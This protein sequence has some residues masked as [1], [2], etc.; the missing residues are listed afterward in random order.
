MVMT[1]DQISG[2]IGGQQVMFQNNA[3]HAHQISGVYG[4]GSQ[5]PVMP[6]QNPFPQASS[7]GAAGAM[8][9][10]VGMAMPGVAT[11]ASIAGGMIGGPMGMLDPF[12]MVP[13]AFR[14]GAGFARGAGVMGTLGG[15]GSAAMSNPMGAAGM[16]GRGLMAGSLAAAPYMMAGQAISTVGENIYQGVQNINQVGGIMG[17]QGGA[18][19]GMSRGQIR[20]VVGVLREFSSDDVMMSMKEAISL[21]DVAQR[22]GMLSGVNNVQQFK[23]RFKGLVEQVKNISEV[24]G[25]TIQEAAPLMGQANQMGLWTTKDITGFAGAAQTVGMQNAPHLMGAMQAG[26]GASRAMG[27]RMGAG[28]RMGQNMFMG[29][30]A[31]MGAGVLTP[32]SLMEMTGGV[33]G[34]QGMQMMAGQLTGTASR[35][36]GSP[37]GRLMMAGLGKFEE[38]RFTG[39]IDEEMLGRFT[40]GDISVGALQGIGRRRTGTRSGA[41]SYTTQSGKIGQEMMAQGGMAGLGQ[42]IQAVMEGAGA[43]GAGKD[44]Q[45]LFIQNLLG[46][47][48]GEAEMWQNL[49]QELPKIQERRYDMQRRA[50]EDAGRKLRDKRY[51][52]MAGM[53]DAIGHAFEQSV[54]PIQQMAEAASTRIGNQMDEMVNSFW[55]SAAPVNV[56]GADRRR[57]M[58]EG[59][60]SGFQAMGQAGGMLG[61]DFDMGIG[62]RVYAAS[63][64]SSGIVSMAENFFTQGT[65]AGTAKGLISRIAS[66]D[67]RSVGEDA[68][69]GAGDIALV[70]GGGRKVVMGRSRAEQVLKR[71]GMR[72]RNPTLASLGYGKGGDQDDLENN[73]QKMRNSYV[74]FMT[75]P[76]NA[77]KLKKLKKTFGG[78]EARYMQAVNRMLMDDPAFKDAAEKIMATG[79]SGTRTEK[80]L[81]M[82]SVLAKEGDAGGLTVDF[83]KVSEDAGADLPPAGER[84]DKWVAEGRSQAAELTETGFLSGA[85]GIGTFLTG[86]AL[87]FAGVAIGKRLGIIGESLTSGDIADITGAEWSAEA[88]EWIRGGGDPGNLPE[89]FKDAL[90]AGDKRAVRLRDT[91]TSMRESDPSSL[92]KF[93]NLLSREGLAKRAKFTEE[94]IEALKTSATKES[95]RFTKVSGKLGEGVA[96][97]YSKILDAYRSGNQDQIRGVQG[98]ITSLAREIS[99]D[100]GAIGALR[101]AGATGRHIAGAAM[102]ERFGDA[103]FMTAGQAGKKLQQISKTLGY[104]VTSLL[105]EGERGELEEA[106]SDGLDV[107]E[108]RDIRKKLGKRVAGAG[109]QDRAA[110]V[111]A[112]QQKLTDSLSKFAQANESF[113]WAVGANVAG[114]NS[115]GDKLKAMLGELK[116]K[117]GTE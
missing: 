20:D 109:P 101:G 78:D 30:Q 49:I 93:S 46:T 59:L 77:D 36:A 57:F 1:S 103:T 100:R 80:S 95:E 13:S 16:V 17:R 96:E 106:M 18:G 28:A 26:A 79:G 86:G 44:V 85:G 62:G 39:G 71:V 38:G 34:A 91:V 51:K 50:I 60:G 63:R 3:S 40:S 23:T 54:S 32:Q 29:I 42:A 83:R 6:A 84:L 97:K 31:A 115:E 8:V 11:A 27:G 43:G 102:V 24:L 114:M 112:S 47:G 98:D 117:R 110:V 68:E 74:S 15:I 94:S 9:G 99:G 113:V 14:A 12:T 55:G 81:D 5:G 56:S 92:Q 73:L 75:N 116:A 52:S 67:A 88:I 33:G 66:E 65:G 4:M 19:G 82:M 69:V 48:S 70:S 7:G 87:G 107:R 2:L 108:I 64:R 58:R 10:G 41:A 21:T 105:S 53:K 35:F 90:M 111:E 22:S 72:G 76:A 61:T 89:A 104:D 37:M 45:N 25:T